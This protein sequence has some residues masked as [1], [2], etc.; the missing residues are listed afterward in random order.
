MFDF[1]ILS[2]D[3]YKLILLQS[4]DSLGWNALLTG[5][6]YLMIDTFNYF[7]IPTR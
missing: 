3:Y 2:S 6:V 4:F 5:V 1:Q 7:I